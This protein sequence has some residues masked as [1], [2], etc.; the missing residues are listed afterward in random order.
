M[1]DLK[2]KILAEFKKLYNVVI[3]EEFDSIKA[4]YLNY[5]F[6]YNFRE[7]TLVYNY[8]INEDNCLSNINK[9]SFTIFNCDEITVTTELFYVVEFK[10]GKILLAKKYLPLNFT[11]NKD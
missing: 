7:K 3:T 9:D 10:C 5:Q 8:F 11:H 6:I 1:E 4:Q 2:S